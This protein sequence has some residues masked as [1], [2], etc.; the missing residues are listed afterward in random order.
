MA[1][2]AVALIV[3]TA[4][5]VV[6]TARLAVRPATPVDDLPEGSARSCVG[7]RRGSAVEGR[8]HKACAGVTTISVTALKWAA[9]ASTT[10]LWN[11]SW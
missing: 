2:A 1:L 7:R 5:V 6:R 3:W 10:M 11:N 8:T 9:A 4:D